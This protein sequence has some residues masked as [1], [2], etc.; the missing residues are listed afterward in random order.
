VVSF[1]LA[2]HDVDTAT[3][4]AAAIDKLAD[5]GPITHTLFSYPRLKVFAS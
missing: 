4:V 1:E 3:Q 2:K 5:D